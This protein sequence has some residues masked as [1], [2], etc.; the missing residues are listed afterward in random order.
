MDHSQ[1]IIM[2]RIAIF[3]SGS[4]T[5]AENL[6]R[7][8][9]NNDRISISLILTNRKNAGVIDRVKDYDIPVL[10]IPNSTWDNSPAKIPEILKEYD[11]DLIV[12][13]GFMHFIAPP[14]V[15]AFKNRILNI[16]PSLLPAYGGKGMW[17]HHV[18]EAVIKA[19]EA[20]SG[21][22]VHYVTE[23]ID[24]GEII[25]QKSIDVLPDDTPE[26]LEN[27]IHLL[28][29]E[30]YPEAVLKAVENI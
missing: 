27:R 16:H 8:F 10:Y 30:L 22:T 25:L 20:K 17:G 28:E 14:I 29:Y 26:T 24:G 6:A 2:T 13:A 11:I 7:K 3:A 4:G 5:N 12:L 15:A 21:V 18:H 23:E 19:R 1:P 9:Q